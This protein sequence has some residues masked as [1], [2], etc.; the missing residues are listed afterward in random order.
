MATATFSDRYARPNVAITIPAAGVNFA[1][2]TTGISA[3][4]TGTLLRVPFSLTPATSVTG[5]QWYLGPLLVGYTL[6]GYFID[7]PDMDSSTGQAGELGDIT[8]LG[9]YIATATA[10]GQS[11][12]FF[13]SGTSSQVAA[14]LPN[15]YSAYPTTGNRSYPGSTNSANFE[16]GVANDLIITLTTGATGTF[17]GSAI[18]GFY[19][20]IQQPYPVGTISTAY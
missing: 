4:G 7:M 2:Q 19:D 16:I 18:K 15:F 3:T 1:P 11:Q 5:D 17:T 12:G 6:T 20:L 8:T 9:K 10:M 13:I 14:S